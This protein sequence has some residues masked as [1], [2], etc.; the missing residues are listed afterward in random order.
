MLFSLGLQPVFEKVEFCSNLSVDWSTCDGREGPAD[1]T[2]LVAYRTYN[3]DSD[4]DD[5]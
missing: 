4:A 5:D 3:D 1:I 2:S